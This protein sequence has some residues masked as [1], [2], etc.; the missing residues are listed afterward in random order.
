MN[1]IPQVLD[2]VIRA[3]RTALQVLLALA[4]FLAI[5]AVVW[6]QIVDAIRADDTS[7]IGLFLTG[8]VAWITAAASIAARIMAI[9]LVNLGLQ[10]IGLA[11]HSG[12]ATGNAD[13]FTR[14]VPVQAPAAAVDPQH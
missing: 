3:A 10:R 4:S 5:A 6:P 14:F 13:T 8:S 2:P 1:T 12:E 7:T 9:P 11:G